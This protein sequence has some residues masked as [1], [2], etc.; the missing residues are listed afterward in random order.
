MVCRLGVSAPVHDPIAS[1]G[2]GQG[3]DKVELNLANAVAV[4]LPEWKDDRP[5]EANMRVQLGRETF[6]R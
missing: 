2:A 5:E 4:L 3:A 6:P 1:E